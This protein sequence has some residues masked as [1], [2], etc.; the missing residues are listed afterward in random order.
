MILGTSSSFNKEAQ[1]SL[2]KLG[3]EGRVL[4]VADIEEVNTW[5]SFETTNGALVSRG[6]LNAY[7]ILVSDWVIFTKETLPSSTQKKR[8][9]RS[10]D[11]IIEPVVPEVYGLLEDTLTVVHKWLQTRN[12]DAIETVL[13]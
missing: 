2:A 6:E 3:A 11:V 13:M 4:I 7:D 9:E 1:N 12:K 8:N 10:R 5:K